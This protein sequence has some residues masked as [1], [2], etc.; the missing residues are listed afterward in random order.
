MFIS[1]QNLPNKR[2]ALDSLDS[3]ERKKV[4]ETGLCIYEQITVIITISAQK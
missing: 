4:D 3:R 2:A 1:T